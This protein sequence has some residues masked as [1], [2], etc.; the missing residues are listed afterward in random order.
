[1]IA[2]FASAV[3][4]ERVVSKGGIEAWFVR[5]TSVPILSIEFLFRGG[6]ALE[7]GLAFPGFD[8]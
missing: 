8:R 4:V 2:G 7:I 6:A 5:D 1:M 3:Q